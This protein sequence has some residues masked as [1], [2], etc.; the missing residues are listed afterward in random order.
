MKI[1]RSKNP[2]IRH[3]QW[4]SQCP[5]KS[6]IIRGIFPDGTSEEDGSDNR[7]VYLN[8]TIGISEPGIRFHER[9]EKVCLIELA[10]W[11]DLQKSNRSNYQPSSDSPRPQHTPRRNAC[12]DCGKVH[13]E[14]FEFDQGSYERLVRPT[15][16][17]WEKWCR[18]AYD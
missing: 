2:V 5:S 3:S 6:P 17:K 12:K 11:S 10:A 8:G 13:C 4:S 14:I 9:W 18:F 16:L 15:I 1:G 7:R